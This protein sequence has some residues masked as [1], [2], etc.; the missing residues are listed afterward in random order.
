MYYVFQLRSLKKLNKSELQTVYGQTFGVMALDN[1]IEHKY[2][3]I[4]YIIDLESYIYE[5]DD[6]HVNNFKVYNKL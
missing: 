6:N 3:K 1:A 2:K 4:D 5:L